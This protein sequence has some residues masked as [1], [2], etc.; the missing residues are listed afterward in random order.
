MEVKDIFELRKQ[1]KI[2][3]A[4]EAI[5]PMYAVHQGHYTTI[6]MFW[7]AS[8]MI[9]L[10]IKQ[11]RVDE[12]LKIFQ[13]LQRLYP[14]LDDADRKGH[15]AMLRHAISLSE[16]T[17][18]FSIVDFLENG[19]LESLDANDWKNL[20]VNGHPMPSIVSRLI[21]R[22][23]HELEDN[24]TPEFGLRC[25]PIL[26]EAL[27]HSRNNMNY[28]RLMALIYKITGETQKAIDIYKKL[29]QKHHQSY[30]YSELAALA[31]QTSNKIPLL[32]KAILMQKEEKFRVKLYFQLAMLLTDSHPQIAA[33]YLNESIRLRKEGGF[34]VSQQQQQM[35]KQLQGIQP[36]GPAVAIS[37]IT[38][39]ASSV[40]TIIS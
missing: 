16:A 20:E 24:P 6:A 12:A 9:K 30:L 28:L 34:H 33:F 25:T 18:L 29:L 31:T 1:G 14:N 3:E 2:E 22:V 39:Q 40:N 15:N 10:R 36:A 23:Y 17:P 37:F 8:D 35:E 21:G 13:A 27:R 38:K 7:C 32:S 26:N 19:G 5:R 4:Y 11:Q